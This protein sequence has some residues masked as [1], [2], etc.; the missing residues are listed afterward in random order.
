MKHIAVIGLGFGDEGKGLT[1]AYLAAKENNAIVIRFSGGQQAGHTVHKDGVS[2]VFSNFGSGTL[3]H[4]PTYWSKYCTVDPVG[5]VNEL[6]ALKEK[7]VVPVI[8]VDGLCPITTPFDKL[9]NQKTDD[10]N[11]TCGTG[12]GST[13]QREEDLYSL[14]VED[15]LFPTILKN[16]VAAIAKYY[17]YDVNNTIVKK[18]L[19]EFYRYVN[20]FTQSMNIFIVNGKTFFSEAHT[21][22]KRKIFEGSQGLML[23]P[24]IGFFPNVTRS[25]IDTTN[26]GQLVKA[27]DTFDIYLVTRCYQTRHGNGPMTNEHLDRP[28]IDYSRETNITNQYQ[29]AFRKTILDVD[30]L[31]YAMQKE[32]HTRTIQKN[33]INLVITCFDHIV[34]GKY[35]F[36]QNGK[37]FEFDT[38]ESFAKDLSIR[39]IGKF[40]NVY[41]SFSEDGSKIKK[42][43][44]S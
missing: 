28:D 31:R 33:S 17:K 15:L 26:I 23:S 1:T 12:F 36:T 3:S 35:K 2:H 8:Y 22:L 13:W 6:Y 27:S 11:G 4:V 42:L 21:Q 40:D 18:H 10:V 34:D 16:K 44:N 39:L 25:Y 14:V 9:H 30:L 5:M 41:L 29:G 37:L 7:G 20:E 32:L 38:P 24:N 43:Q 19:I